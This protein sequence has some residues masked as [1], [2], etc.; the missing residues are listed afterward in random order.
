MTDTKTLREEIDS[1]KE[2]NRRVETDKAWETSWFRI[3]LLTIFIYLVATIFMI[4]VEIAKPWINALIPAV[5]YFLSEQSLP[6]IKKW[7]IKKRF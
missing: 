5:G 7:W 3:I 6:F 2:R 1:I 4:F